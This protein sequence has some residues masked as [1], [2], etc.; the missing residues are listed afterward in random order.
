LTINLSNNYEFKSVICIAN[1]IINHVNKYM[2]LIL[3][4]CKTPNLFSI[5]NINTYKKSIKDRYKQI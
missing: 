3:L 2:A 4:S 5:E 1:K